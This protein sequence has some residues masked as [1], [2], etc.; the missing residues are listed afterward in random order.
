[1]NLQVDTGSRRSRR[2]LLGNG[3]LEEVFFYSV[4][5]H[6]DVLDQPS[7]KINIVGAKRKAAARTS[8]FGSRSLDFGL[9]LKGLLHTFDAQG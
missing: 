4:L 3:F 7:Q 8:F 5:C 6:R 2:P 9:W 1:M